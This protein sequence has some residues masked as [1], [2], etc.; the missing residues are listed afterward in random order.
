MNSRERIKNII[1][2][3]QADR[4]GFWLGNPHD[5]TWPILHKYFGTKTEEELRLKLGD[6]FRWIS[7]Q[8]F[9]DAYNDPEGRKMFDEGL[10]KDIHGRAGP[11][12][13]CV[14]IE[15]VES[16]PWPRPEYLCFDACLDTLKN[17]GDVYRASGFWTCFY[18]NVMDLFG[19]E[20]YMIKMLTHPE[21]V[22]AVT[23][24]VC[25]FY[26]KANEMFFEAAGDMVDGF[27]FGNDFGTQQNLICGPD[28]FNEF[29]MPWFRKFTKQAHDY[30]YQ[31]I[32]HSCGAIHKVIDILIEADV[33]CL[34]PLQA[35]AVDMN[36]ERLSADFKGKIAFM[37]GIDTQY[38]LVNGTPEEIKN[39]VNRVKKL[40]GPN[41]IISPSHEAI[42]P[43]VPPENIKA[44]AEAV[45]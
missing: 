3:K 12:A 40:L 36:A 25:E 44:M 31:A 27:F 11:F 13:D 34:H 9:H 41:L 26:H 4:C 42:L 33:D 32:L 1:A 37:G 19:M 30:G 28:Q 8:F 14:D 39:D 22:H 10:E 35:K 21:I 24:K 17:A 43:N 16:Y 5:D 18:H 20:S 45:H 15:E 29:I 6:D 7:P 38:L 23:D 2:G